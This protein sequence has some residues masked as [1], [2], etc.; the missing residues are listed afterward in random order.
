MN[1]NQ[2]KRESP[3]Q[4]RAILE[5]MPKE[6]GSMITHT[7]E[8]V[9]NSPRLGEHRRTIIYFNHKDMA[10]VVEFNAEWDKAKETDE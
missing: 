1:H 3:E 10:K 9:L 7:R 2:I 8:I 6:Y 4:I 5:K